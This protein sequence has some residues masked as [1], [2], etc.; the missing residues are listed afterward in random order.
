MYK[1]VNNEDIRGFKFQTS[2]EQRYKLFSSLKEPRMKYY[3]ILRFKWVHN[4]AKMV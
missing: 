3:V 1:R 2:Q 4:E